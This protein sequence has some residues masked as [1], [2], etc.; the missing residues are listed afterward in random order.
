M[1]LLQ[2]GVPDSDDE[3]EDEQQWLHEAEDHFDEVECDSLNDKDLTFITSVLDSFSYTKSGAN[4]MRESSCVIRTLEGATAQ[5]KAEP[6]MPRE[7]NQKFNQN[8]KK[9]SQVSE[10]F[11][12]FSAIE[13]E[14]DTFSDTEETLSES[15]SEEFEFEFETL[16]EVVAEDAEDQTPLSSVNSISQ[17]R[18]STFGAWQ[19]YIPPE[20]VFQN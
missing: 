10:K 9:E 11:S 14:E 13:E 1:K 5:A 4:K 8:S 20:P 3:D 12:C 17:E 18:R 2:Q 15:D 7:F 19:P 6:M 16:S